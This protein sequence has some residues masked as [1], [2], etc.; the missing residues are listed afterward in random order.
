[1]RVTEESMLVSCINLSKDIL[2]MRELIERAAYVAEDKGQTQIY[3]L[4]RE[5]LEIGKEA[6]E[7]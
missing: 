3:C 1:M 7:S 4:L 6:V 5:A 2:R